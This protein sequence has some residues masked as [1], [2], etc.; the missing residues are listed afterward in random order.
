MPSLPARQWHKQDR[1]YPEGDSR[2]IR[3]GRCASRI[4]SA[5]VE[6]IEWRKGIVSANRMIRG[7]SERG[8][9]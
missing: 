2:R 9:R 8:R 5:V 6:S 1:K 3:E 4:A 7:G